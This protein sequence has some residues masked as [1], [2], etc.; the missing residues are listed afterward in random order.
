MTRE[1]EGTSLLEVYFEPDVDLNSRGLFLRYVHDHLTQHG[2]NVARLRHYC[3]ANKKCKDFEKPFKDREAIEEAL[4]PGGAGKVFCGKCGKPILLHDVIEK[5][6]ESPAVKEQS[7]VMQ[8]EVED[9]LDNE[10]RELI[11]VGHAFSVTPTAI[12]GSMARSSSR[13]TRAA[14]P[15]SIS[16]CSSSPAIPTSRSADATTR[17]FFRS[18]TR[19]GPITG[20]SRPIPSC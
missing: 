9:A 12:T 5:L 14:P 1:S 8:S 11:L 18:R 7:R 3:C 2:Q 15:A 6:F 13:T 16:T 19:A 17:K 10:S 4:S 20:G